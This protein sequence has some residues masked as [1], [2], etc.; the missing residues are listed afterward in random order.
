M[1]NTLHEEKFLCLSD[2]QTKLSAKCL[3]FCVSNGVNLIACSTENKISLWDLNTFEK[4]REISDPNKKKIYAL[5]YL[6]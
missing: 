5:L 6:T 4:V 3:K 2:Q 1:R